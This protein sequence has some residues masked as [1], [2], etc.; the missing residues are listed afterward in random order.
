MEYLSKILFIIFV[1]DGIKYQ[2]RVINAEVENLCNK[3]KIWFDNFFMPLN[4]GSIV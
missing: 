2:L 1:Y 3:S 4:S